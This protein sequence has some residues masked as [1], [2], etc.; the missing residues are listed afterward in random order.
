M[1]IFGFLSYLRN[2]GHRYGID[3]DGKRKEGL[4]YVGMYRPIAGK[5]C[6]QSLSYS[7]RP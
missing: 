6:S 1:Y 4:V 7:L 3:R 2:L 5:Y